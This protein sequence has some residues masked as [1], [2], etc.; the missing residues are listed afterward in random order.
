[1]MLPGLL[2]ASNENDIDELLSQQE[3][4]SGVVFEVISWDNDTLKWAIPAVREYS[5]RLRK[6]FPDID[7]AVVSHGMEQFALLKN[8]ENYYGEV[9]DTV[10]SLVKDDIPVHVCETFARMNDVNADEFPDYVN[11]SSHGPTQIQDY[12]E[13]GYHHIELTR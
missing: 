13:L 8:K 11:V 7:I 2:I 12:I 10:R 9:H 1:M 6:R 3:T 4:P 5:D